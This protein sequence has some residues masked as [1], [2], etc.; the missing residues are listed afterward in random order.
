MKVDDGLYIYSH[1]QQEHAAF[2]LQDIVWN[3]RKVQGKEGEIKET[4]VSSNEE[5]IKRRNKGGKVNGKGTSSMNVTFLTGEGWLCFLGRP[6]AGGVAILNM[7]SPNPSIR[8]EW[9]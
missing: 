6:A 1:S 4:R 7:L 3:D 2:H 9:I 5:K 8:I